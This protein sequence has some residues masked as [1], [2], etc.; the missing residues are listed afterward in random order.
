M[1]ENKLDDK[2]LITV[3]PDDWIEF[4][5]QLGKETDRGVALV[6]AAFLENLLGALLE[7]F[8]LEDRKITKKL[9]KGPLAPFGG[10]YPRTIASYSLGLISADEMHD[11][12][13]IR[14]VRNDF[15]HKA[16]SLSFS[17]P[18]VQKKLKNLRV[19]HL[20]PDEIFDFTPRQLYI[21]SVSM[22]STFLY[23]RRK[24]TIRRQPA[25][26]F[27]IDLRDKPA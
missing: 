22:I 26:K 9:L 1:E 10:F 3:H 12:D 19:P 13:I 21:N 27:F 25:K 2:S 11:L 8:L 5:T 20:I 15:A 4:S 24:I 16:K 17:T 6:G 7:D 18:S 14:S 23:K